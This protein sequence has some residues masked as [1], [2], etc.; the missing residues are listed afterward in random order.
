[1]KRSARASLLAFGLFTLASCALPPRE[2]WRVIRHDGLIP[3]VGVELGRRPVPPYVRLPA[4]AGTRFVTVSPSAKAPGR[5][6]AGGIYVRRP[7][8]PLVLNRYLDGGPPAARRPAPPVIA[9]APRPAPPVSAVPQPAPRPLVTAP[10]PK[11]ALRPA[12]SL[13]P[14]VKPAPRPVVNAPV[15]KPAPRVLQP[16]PASKLEKPAASEIAAAPKAKSAPPVA[17]EK[18]KAS[19]LAP[20]PPKSGSDG[21]ETAKAVAPELPFG[22]PIPGRP[23]LVNSPYAGKYQL[24]DVTGLNPGQEVKCPYTGK[25]FRV[26][27]AQ[28]AANDVKAVTEPPPKRSDAPKN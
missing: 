13:P 4:V 14:V 23:G 8:S 17:P 10:V 25:I 18:P 24:V 22:A 19:A 6:A 3:Y 28:Q 5:A 26:P 11:P 2:A 1:M 7:G 12:P 27:G 15:S 16:A 21:V 9:L 20:A